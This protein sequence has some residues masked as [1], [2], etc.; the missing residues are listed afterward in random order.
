ME[1]GKGLLGLLRV[2]I[3]IYLCI[4]VHVVYQIPLGASLS[5]RSQSSSQRIRLRRSNLTSSS[6]SSSSSTRR[7]LR[8][9]STTST[10]VAIVAPSPA[11]LFI[12]TGNL[13]LADLAVFTTFRVWP[14]ST[15][16]NVF[17]C[18]CPLF[19]LF[20]SFHLRLY[21]FN[22]WWFGCYIFTLD[23]CGIKT[24]RRCRSGVRY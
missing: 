3:S 21:V 2:F 8:S 14:F 9:A 19:F 12:V 13:E 5:V 24:R 23:Y 4:C 15:T 1:E 7:S 10:T 17:S 16:N 20:L 22:L 11:P 6:S 18:E